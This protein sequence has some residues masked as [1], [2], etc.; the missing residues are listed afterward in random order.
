MDNWPGSN[1]DLGMDMQGN[2]LQGNVVG[3]VA[4]TVPE[5]RMSRKKTVL[6]VKVTVQMS[7]DDWIDEVPIEHRVEPDCERQIAS[8]NEEC[9]KSRVKRSVSKNKTE[10]RARAPLRS[11]LARRPA[12]ERARQRSTTTA[13]A[14]ATP[15]AA[16]TRRCQP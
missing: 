10:N 12:E 11:L 3:H 16:W 7:A 15:L 1:I 5:Q 14:S 9:L 2:V 8:V 13:R 6:N 4:E